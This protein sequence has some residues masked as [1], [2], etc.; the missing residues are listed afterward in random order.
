M[1]GLIYFSAVRCADAHQINYMETVSAPAKIILLGEHAVV[2][3]QP[4]LAVPLSS[5][6]T[7]AEIVNLPKGSGLKVVAADLNNQEFYVNS[8]S[9]EIDSPLFTAAWLLLNHL[10]CPPPDATITLHSDI[11]IAS[12]M[13][14]G[15]AITT[16][17]F[18]ALLLALNQSLSSEKLNALAYEVEKIHHGTP[19]GIDNTVI[20]FEQP[21]YFVR[22]Q[23]IERLTIGKPFVLLVGNTGIG[24]STKSVVSDVRT[25]YEANVEFITEKFNSIGELVR[26]GRKAIELGDHLNLGKIMYDNHQFLQEISVS[27][28]SLDML[29][30]AARTSGALGAKLSGAGRGGN[31]IALVSPD[32]APTIKNALLEA[33][34][35]QVYQTIV[36]K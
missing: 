23:P 31:M 14:S 18:R 36:G 24:S 4:S 32:K 26:S 17:L 8:A 5:L 13:G 11:P 6:R 27:S 12:G 21:I 29:V 34:A 35:V 22:G 20:V 25:L 30:D 19:S 3:G 16:A 9:Q 10:D 2:Y 28:P 7:Y 1:G 33:G 15:A